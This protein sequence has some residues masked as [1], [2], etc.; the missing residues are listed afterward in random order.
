[1]CN[2]KPRMKVRMSS[3]VPR[4]QILFFIKSNFCPS[5]VE[6]TQA[7]TLITIHTR[8]QL[9]NY[10]LPIYCIYMHCLNKILF[11]QIHLDTQQKSLLPTGWGLGAAD[12][13]IYAEAVQRKMQFSAARHFRFMRCYTARSRRVVPSSPSLGERVWRM[14]R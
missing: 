14:F 1:M 3:P 4:R 11:A 10:S 5:L 7:H 6:N 9:F 12:T 2:S 13:A 8:A